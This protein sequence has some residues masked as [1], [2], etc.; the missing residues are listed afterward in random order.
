MVVVAVAVAAAAACI[1]DRYLVEFKEETWHLCALLMT[2][3][4][5][6]TVPSLLAGRTAFKSVNK[7][8]S[9]KVMIHYVEINTFEV[10][11]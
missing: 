7:Q 11:G 2:F 9:V 6:I 5:R 1:L 3:F 4:Y 8:F 10:N